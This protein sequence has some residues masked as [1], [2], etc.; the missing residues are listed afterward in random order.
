MDYS[1]FKIAV[2]NRPVNELHLQ[3]LIKNFKDNYLGTT[4]I[5]N[6][7]YEIIDGQHRYFACKKLGL[8]FNVEIKK[9]FGVKEMQVLN[10]NAKNWTC[11]DYL[12]SYIVQNNENYKILKNYMK[13][14]KLPITIC[15]QLLGGCVNGDGVKIFQNG[16]FE[17]KELREAEILGESLQTIGLFY[18]DYTRRS[19]VNAIIKL[20]KNKDFD[21]DEFIEKI[22]GCDIKTYS[23][24]EDYI[25][26][27]EQIYNY[28][29]RNKV[30]LRIG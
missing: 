21:I 16:K 30:N 1:K 27:I 9:G 5:V 18:K 28:R 6:E 22:Q 8:D 25:T 24:V 19:F 15:I 17:V 11:F 7:N 23:K 4:I 10:A 3:R 12:E 13:K 20:N 26:R 29:R 2:G 14:Y